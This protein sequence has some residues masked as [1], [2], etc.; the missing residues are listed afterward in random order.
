MDL[1]FEAEGVFENENENEDVDEDE[2]EEDGWGEVGK[3][4]G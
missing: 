2:D 1:R 4:G 3:G